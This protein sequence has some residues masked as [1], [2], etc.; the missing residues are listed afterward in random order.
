MKTLFYSPFSLLPKTS[1]NAQ[2][3]S[4]PIYGFN[5]KLLY[6]DE[7]LYTSYTLH[8]ELGDH[9]KE[10]FLNNVFKNTPYVILENLKEEYKLKKNQK[11]FLDYMSH[12]LKTHATLPKGLTIEQD[13]ELAH[14]LYKRGFRRIKFKVSS[15]F[16]RDQE[17]Y[18]NF[19]NQYKD[20]E[21]IF[22]FNTTGDFRDFNDL[23]WSSD[24]LSRTFWEDPLNHQIV[25]DDLMYLKAKDFK[26]ILD[27]KDMLHHQ[28]LKGLDD[29]Y[30]IVSVKP[31]KES[32][33]EVLDLFPKAKILVTT[34]M[35]D[36]T[37]HVISAYWANYIFSNFSER[38]FG[39]GLYTRHFFNYTK[40]KEL[41]PKVRTSFLNLNH[42]LLLKGWGLDQEMGR[43]EWIKLKDLDIEF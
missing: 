10:V 38:F 28:K 40:S 21:F 6:G 2:H 15:D 31:T 20:I 43:K 5:F 33:K 25:V 30:D 22:D 17:Y 1:L 24:V 34:N 4:Q 18:F 42:D 27:Q 14:A 23:R 8:T 7:F 35:G 3:K 37:D 9:E 29:V 32:V 13:L 39:A 41:D 36:E 16:F 11:Y 19:L 12:E 26:L